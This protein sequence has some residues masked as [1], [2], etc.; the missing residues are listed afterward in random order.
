MICTL[1]QADS[2]CTSS[3]EARLASEP[4]YHGRTYRHVQPDSQSSLTAPHKTEEM[5]PNATCLLPAQ[6]HGRCKSP[7]R[8]QRRETD[9][10]HSSRVGTAKRNKH[11]QGNAAASEIPGETWI[12][13]RCASVQKGC[14][15]P[16]RTGE[17]RAGHSQKALEQKRARQVPKATPRGAG[18]TARLSIC[19]PGLPG[20]PRPAEDTAS[21]THTGAQRPVPPAPMCCVRHGAHP[22]HEH[23]D[24]RELKL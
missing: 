7:H 14:R 23:P 11:T 15:L 5:H 24:Q 21:P 17:V 18:L 8:E 12:K 10:I 2:H 3:S 16:E 4:A 1:S 19:A 22:T 20:E 9:F 6:F 13:L